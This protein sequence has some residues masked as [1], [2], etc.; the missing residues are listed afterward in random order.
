MKHHSYHGVQ[1]QLN[2]TYRNKFNQFHRVAISPIEGFCGD[3]NDTNQEV[4]GGDVVHS[5][6]YFIEQMFKEKIR[7]LMI[8][9]DSLPQ[10]K[11]INSTETNAQ[12]RKISSLSGHIRGLGT[13][14]FRK[15][16][17]IGCGC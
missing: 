16:E 11:A 1:E 6:F 15:H 17:R 9:A 10:I 14:L 3:K 8:E 2:D 13:F 4:K 5:D 7:Q 12:K